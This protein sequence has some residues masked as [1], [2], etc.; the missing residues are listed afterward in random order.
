MLNFNVLAR[1][2]DS[3]RKKDVRNEEEL[4]DLTEK[5]FQEN[6]VAKVFFC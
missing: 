1:K 2:N 4:G 3:Y 6:V 5:N